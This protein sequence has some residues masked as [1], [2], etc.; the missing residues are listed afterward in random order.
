MYNRGSEFNGDGP[1]PELTAA[2]SLMV[3]G[4]DRDRRGPTTLNRPLLNNVSP[5]IFASPLRV[6]YDC[7]PAPG[8][9]PWST[10]YFTTAKSRRLLVHHAVRP[11]P[12]FF[13][14]CPV[15]S[16]FRFSIAGMIYVDVSWFYLLVLD[17]RGRLSV[18]AHTYY[19]YY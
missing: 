8:N 18:H 15:I 9:A 17:C 14:C 3:T 11:V 12:R 13:P 1:N 2:A 4:R 16:T 6:V 7:H 19:Y 5:V 10:L